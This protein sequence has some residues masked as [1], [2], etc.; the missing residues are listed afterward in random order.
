MTWAKVAAE[1]G[2]TAML[3]TIVVGLLPQVLLGCA[4]T[5]AALRTRLAC[6]PVLIALREL[7]Q[8]HLHALPRPL[9][10]HDLHLAIGECRSGFQQYMGPDRPP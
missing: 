7:T 4:P 2:G 6:T 3:L 1:F 5:I 10:F 8:S 9:G